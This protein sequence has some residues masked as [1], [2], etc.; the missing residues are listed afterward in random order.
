M[1]LTNKADFLSGSTISML[2]ALIINRVHHRDDN[3]NQKLKN[4]VPGE[5]CGFCEIV[6]RQKDK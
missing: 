5:Q 6:A 1:I 3:D 4:V 2:R